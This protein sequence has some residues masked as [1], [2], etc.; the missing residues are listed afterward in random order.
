MEFFL[1]H[2]RGHSCNGRGA[3][4]E[5]KAKKEGRLEVHSENDDRT[6]GDT[7]KVAFWHKLCGLQTFYGAEL[8]YWPTS[9]CGTRSSALVPVPD[10]N[11]GPRR[12]L[13]DAA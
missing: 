4:N 10:G 9:I 5:A 13:C 6:V 3:G 8:S 1:F 12:Y 11:V 7:V 2:H